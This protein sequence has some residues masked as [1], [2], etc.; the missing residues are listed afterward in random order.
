ML[1]WNLYTANFTKMVGISLSTAVLL[2]CPGKYYA[3]HTP[4]NSDAVTKNGLASVRATTTIIHTHF[5]PHFIRTGWMN[6]GCN[7]R[8]IALSYVH[9]NATRNVPSTI[10]SFTQQQTDAW[11]ILCLYF[12]VC[13]PC[14]VAHI[15]Q[16]ICYPCP[17]TNDGTSNFINEIARMNE[18]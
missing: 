9:A 3:Q 11:I 7:I 1:R 12:A 15:A 10:V 14:S 18:F 16:R 5:A 8:S 4:E 17:P 13:S 2:H 6:G